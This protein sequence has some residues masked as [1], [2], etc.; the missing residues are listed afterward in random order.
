MRVLS[1]IPEGQEVAFA[2]VVVG[3]ARQRGPRRF[4]RSPPPPYRLRGSVVL[5]TPFAILLAALSVIVTTGIARDLVGSG[6]GSAMLVVANPF[7]APQGL[8][9]G[10]INGLVEEEGEEEEE[11]TTTTTAAGTAAAGAPAVAPEPW[12]YSAA[13]G[14][15]YWGTLDAKWAACASGKTQSPIDL[16]ADTAKGVVTM[17][18]GVKDVHCFKDWTAQAQRPVNNNGHTLCTTLDS[19]KYPTYKIGED[20]YQ[21][22]YME[23]HTPSEH[24]ILGVHADL[25]LQLYATKQGGT[26]R[27]VQSVLFE[28]R[29]KTQADTLTFWQNLPRDL[30]KTKGATKPLWESVHLENLLKA[31]DSFK[32]A[33]TYTGSFTAPPCAESVK[34][35]V[36]PK[37]L[38]M[39]Y[40]HMDVVRSIIGFNARDIQQIV[41]VA[42]EY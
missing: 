9:E 34:W 4:R 27:A 5:L 6:D 19:A 3:D 21:V 33:Y 16:A 11:T 13:K 40:W 29:D 32:G 41:P 42:E 1:V 17:V 38:P 20:V 12:D 26:D 24:R 37:V 22:K 39:C 10:E 8:T 7:P 25:E 31:V 36:S 2:P 14:P 30:P 23:I 28:A 15:R 35:I 18:D